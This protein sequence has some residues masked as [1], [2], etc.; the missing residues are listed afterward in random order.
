M[1][2]VLSSNALDLVHSFQGR[3][4]LL[5]GDALLDSYLEGE[6]ARL[7]RDGPIPVVRKT[8]EQRLPG[9]AANVAANLQALGAHVSFVSVVG[10]DLAGTL[11]RE[12]LRERGIEDR[13]LVEVPTISTPH[14]LRIMADGQH[15]ARFDEGASSASSYPHEA[16]QALLAHLDH[17]YALCDAVMLSDY[18]Y[19]VLS[20]ALIAWLHKKYQTHPKFF[21][22]DAQDLTPFSQFPATIV[23]PNAQEASRFVNGD[24]RQWSLASDASWPEKLQIIE[25]LAWRM[26]T[27]LATKNIAITLAEH[28]VFLLSQQGHCTHFPAHPIAVAHDVGA[29]DSFASALILALAAEGSIEEAIR[30]G[31]D[32]A[33][34]AVT[35]PRTAVVSHQELLQRVSLRA[36]TAQ[37]NF[38]EEGHPHAALA[39]LAAQ[40]EVARLEGKKIVFTN[41]VFDILHVGHLQFLRQAKALG[42]LLVVGVNSDASARRLKGPG[43]PINNEQDRLALVTALDM[44]DA[45]IL[46]EEDTASELIRTL[47]PNLYV[48]GGDHTDATLPEASIVHE[49]GGHIIILPLVGSIRTSDVIARIKQH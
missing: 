47:S 41:G 31:I 45:T 24:A 39:R 23:T 20:S 18:G 5:V 15:I 37:A 12:T 6:A 26:R 27:S 13:W 2:R 10:K 30:I 46:F 43:R 38:T 42:D 4:I 14:K 8:L 29:G 9:G 7:S 48:K 35:R 34:I 19:G 28:G 22:V 32:A 44:V 21:L 17:L 49:V 36:Y 25:Q 1:Y 33:G 40:L 11:L 3:R 16:Q